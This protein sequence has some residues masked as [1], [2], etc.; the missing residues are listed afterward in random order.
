MGHVDYITTH[1]PVAI[2]RLVDSDPFAQYLGLLSLPRHSMVSVVPITVD[3]IKSC[4]N[5]GYQPIVYLDDYDLLPYNH[6]PHFVVVT[7]YDR[8]RITIMDPWN[9]LIKDIHGKVLEHAITS[10]K[11]RLYFCPQI[12]L[13]SKRT[14]PIMEVSA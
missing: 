10:L 8:D 14:A 9:G 13:V 3:H 6:C 7:G 2:N 12:L 11:R 4:V 5:Q 1:F